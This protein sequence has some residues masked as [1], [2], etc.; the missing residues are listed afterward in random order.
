MMNIFSCFTTHFTFP[1]RKGSCLISGGFPPH[2]FCIT[3]S[4]SPP[5]MILLFSIYRLPFCHTN[6]ITKGFLGMKITGRA[7][8]VFSTIITFFNDFVFW[9]TFFIA[10]LVVTFSRTINS[11]KALKRSKFFFTCWANL[12]NGMVFI[13][14]SWHNYFLS[15]ST[16]FVKGNIEIEEKYCEI[17][18]DRLRQG[19]FNFSH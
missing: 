5:W 16:P 6:I 12:N 13:F 4:T 18:V 2:S 7:H 9:L 8:H 15:F 10:S 17:A 3:S 14:K 11:L 1:I 19:V